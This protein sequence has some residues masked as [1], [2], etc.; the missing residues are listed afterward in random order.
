MKHYCYCIAF[1]AI[2]GVGLLAV[3]AFIASEYFDARLIDT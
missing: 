2:T 3:A 1:G